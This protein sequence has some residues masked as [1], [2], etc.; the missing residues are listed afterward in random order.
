MV[1]IK[2]PAIPSLVW[3]A[4]Q[5]S[6]GAKLINWVSPVRWWKCLQ[7]WHVGNANMLGVT[8]AVFNPNQFGLDFAV[9]ISLR[10][11]WCQK[12]P[13]NDSSIMFGLLTIDP[14]SFWFIYSNDP[15]MYTLDSL[16][17]CSLGI[18]IWH[19]DLKGF[20]TLVAWPQPEMPMAVLATE[21]GSATL[22]TG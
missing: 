2:Y 12:K 13:L 8:C 4:P 7:R 16:D 11:S 3:F 6:W 18:M 9:Y 22:A 20:D 5:I 15:D 17:Y 21:L 14:R 1:Q 19:L 10:C